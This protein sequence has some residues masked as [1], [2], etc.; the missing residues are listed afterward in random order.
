M[1]DLPIQAVLVLL[2]IICL[3]PATMIFFGLLLFRRGK[4]N[5]NELN[6]ERVYANLTPNQISFIMRFGGA[7][8]L[9][10]LCGIVGIAIAVYANVE[11]FSLDNSLLLLLLLL[12]FLSVVFFVGYRRLS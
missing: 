5:L 6:R 3:F 9:L 1:S 11:I 2:G 12:V 7:S 8:L 4:A 10:M